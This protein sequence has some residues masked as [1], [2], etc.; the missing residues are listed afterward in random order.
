M[1]SG[2]KLSGMPLALAALLAI[3]T[4]VALPVL[5]SENSDAADNS[6]YT[7]SWAGSSIYSITTDQTTIVNNSVTVAAGSTFTFKVVVNADYYDGEM[8]VSS[9]GVILFR[10]DGSYTTPA[11]NGNAVIIVQD[12]HKKYDFVYNDQNNGTVHTDYDFVYE[13]ERIIVDIST[14]TGYSLSNVIVTMG[15]KIIDAYSDGTVV[16]NNVT[17]DVKITVSTNTTSIASEDWMFATIIAVAILFVILF[18]SYR[19]KQF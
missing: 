5:S 8:S 19:N 6:T 13:G 11:I 4:M 9:D 15:G 2:R 1:S 14:K 16:I 3:S 7:V 10:T 18:L 17:D 12:L